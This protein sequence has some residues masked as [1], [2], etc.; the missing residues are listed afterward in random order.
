LKKIEQEIEAQMRVT[1]ELQQDIMKMQNESGGQSNQSQDQALE[2]CITVLLQ[3]FL[4]ARNMKETIRSKQ[5]QFNEM[6]LE[7]K[8]K[9][10]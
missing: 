4:L 7:D 1:E 5:S 6:K 3:E 9:P 10:G 2:G 8:H